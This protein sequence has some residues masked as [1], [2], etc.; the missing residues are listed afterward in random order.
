MAPITDIKRP[1]RGIHKVFSK[2][3]PVQT[4]Q[5]R[6]ERDISV[7]W[8]YKRQNDL[9]PDKLFDVYK[10]K[11]RV[12]YYFIALSTPGT[13][14]ETAGGGC[15]VVRRHPGQSQAAVNPFPIE[16]ENLL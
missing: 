2:R 10:A 11:L 4:A 8:L 15:W 6:P 9:T 1:G 3:T 14:H 5:T 7:L 16:P 13:S 12:D